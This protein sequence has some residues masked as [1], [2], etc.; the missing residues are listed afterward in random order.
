M[1]THT[2]KKK[3]IGPEQWDIWKLA[4]ST[5]ELETWT[6]HFTETSHG[7]SNYF[8]RYNQS[9]FIQVCV[10]LPFVIA[11]R[12]LQ[13]NKTLC[14]VTCINCQFCVTSVQFSHSDYNWEQIKFHLHDNAS[15]NVHLPQ[16]EIFETFSKRLPS[17]T[18]LETLAKQLVDQL[19]GLDP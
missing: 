15:L 19:S 2:H 5:E 10:P 8:F 1:C 6:R 3:Q 9:Y 11:I 7:H 4:T 18:N 14:S 12:N 13:F 17:S 16:K